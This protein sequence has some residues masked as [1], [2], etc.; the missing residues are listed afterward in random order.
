VRL[1]YFNQT[2]SAKT[3]AIHEIVFNVTGVGLS[4]KVRE[5]L[6][7]AV[8][9][10]LAL[11]NISN[12]QLDAVTTS[13][14]TRAAFAK[15]ARGRVLRDPNRI[16]DESYVERVFEA[17]TLKSDYVS[18]E[19]FCAVLGAEGGGPYKYRRT[20]VARTKSGLGLFLVALHSSGAITLPSTFRWPLMHNDKR[21]WIEI[22][23]HVASELL[24]FVRTLDPYS[25]TVSHPAFDVVGGDCYRRSWFL[26]YATR[27]LLATGWHSPEDVNLADLMRIKAAENTIN[28][29]K[30]VPFAFGALLDVLDVAFPNRIKVT[31]KNWAEALRLARATCVE[32]EN[33][34]K[35]WER[36]NEPGP[37]S[38]PDLLNEVL[39]LNSA[40]AKPVRMRSLTRLPGLQVDFPAISKLWL[41]LEELYISKTARENYKGIYSALGWWNI[42]LFYYLPY[43]FD[44][45]SDSPWLFPRSPELLIRSVFVSRLLPSDHSTPTTFVEFISAI[46][47]RRQWKGNN[48]YAVLLQIEEFF[49]FIERFSDELPECKGFTQPI[50][51]HD[52]PR[53]ARPRRSEKLPIPR[54]F[55]GVC[56]DYYEA[57]IAHHAVVL[58][59]V[60]AGELSDG[61]LKRL[62]ANVNIIDTFAT[63]DL[64]G[65]VRIV[66]TPTKTIPLQFIP[67]VLDV[68][69][70]TLRGGQTLALP[71]P[72]ALYQNLVAL[73]TGITHN[74][75]Q[76]LDRDKF[77][78]LVHEADRDFSTLFVNTDKQKTQ[79]WAPH[80]NFRVIELLRAQRQWCDLIESS[81]FNSERFYNDNPR[82]KWPKFRALFGYT[83][84]GKPH[85]DEL[86]SEVWKSILCGLQGLMGELSEFGESGR[87]IRLMPPSPAP[88]YFRSFSKKSPYDPAT[89]KVGDS[90]ILQIYTES[91]PHS[92]RVAVVS[93]YITFLPTDL[94]GKYI[95][96]QK[97]ATVAYYVHIEPEVLEAQQVH[98]ALRMRDAAFKAAFEPV[99]TRGAKSATFIHADEVNSNLAS[100]MQTDFEQTISAHGGICITFG[101][102]TKNGLDVLRETACAD[103]AF[104]KTEICPYGNNCPRD[105]I[106]ELKGLRRCSLCAYAVRFIDHLPAVMVKKR[107]IADAVDALGGVLSGDTKTLYAKYTPGE[108]D[109]L[110]GDRARLCEDLTGWIL[111]EEALEI[112]RQRL[113]SGQDHREWTVQRPEIIERDL[114]RVSV[115]TSES[116]YLLARLGECIAFPTLES[117]QVRARFDVLRR[118]LLARSGN[119]REAFSSTAVDP[120]LECA[121]ML[122][123]I[124]ESRGYTL[125]QIAA[126][127][128]GSSWRELL[129]DPGVS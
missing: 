122:R 39:N 82:T 21:G 12:I 76:W 74:H 58:N 83:A 32:P 1:F 28:D 27:L 17:Y 6:E 7:L 63:S 105:V 20:Y 77:D 129:P 19:L 98:Q 37:R 42:F 71:H 68:H 126:L 41:D 48:F 92:A 127:L 91:T 3:G 73:H 117:P 29:G 36:L 54:R 108:L 53:T 79:P 30:Q 86:Y 99:A 89:A 112:M 61:D 18:E 62:E 24:S 114:R 34:G 69:R 96:G 25:E 2:A 95:T 49:T 43:W 65:F 66:F 15:F 81:G 88:Q 56:L 125:S 64:V 120:A 72:H 52:Y 40:Y 22:G 44:R 50:A 85:S 110:E 46:A 111:N 102:R 101:E 119:I 47:E 80:V 100:S 70:R 9:K 109:L 38:D 94:I 90:C 84:S 118:E 60:L 124:I 78:M 31:S 106:K 93:Q 123:T 16:F 45:R 11:S 67:N 87:L 14:N 8:E 51:A 104:N 116:E 35:A 13:T 10:H 121:G 107:Q 113:S 128:D 57:L 97:S 55:F 33:A 23:K 115:Q 75:I 59:A 5:A 26:S 4:Q 103:I